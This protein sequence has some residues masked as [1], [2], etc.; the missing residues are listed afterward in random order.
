VA[1][2]PLDPYAVLGVATNASAEQIRHAYRALARSLHPDA[3]PHDPVAAERFRSIVEAY[4]Y[5]GDP[6]RRADYDHSRLG[7]RSSFGPRAARSAPGPTGNHAVR[8]QAA[9]PARSPA[10]REPEPRLGGEGFGALGWLLGAAAALIIALMVVFV[11]S[12][13]ISTAGDRPM[14]SVR[15]SP[16]GPGFCKTADGWISCAATTANP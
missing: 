6:A 7:S 12:A 10:E 11:A 14:G 13:L 8:G 1:T 2:Q 5:V 4:R 3:H 16:G 9:H 15:M